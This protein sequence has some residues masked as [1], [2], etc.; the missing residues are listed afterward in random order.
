[1]SVKWSGSAWSQACP[2]RQIRNETGAG[3]LPADSYTSMMVAMVVLTDRLVLAKSRT[4][5][6]RRGGDTDRSRGVERG[7][8]AARR[9]VSVK[10]LPVGIEL[11]GHP[12]TALAVLISQRSHER[13]AVA[14]FRRRSRRPRAAESIDG[15]TSGS[16]AN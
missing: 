10:S 13:S 7:P 12:G 15:G 2:W 11:V 3:G 14:A 5:P 8:G 4:E 9:S 1:M 16:S 6:I